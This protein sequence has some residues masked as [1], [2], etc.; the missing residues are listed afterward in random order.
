MY[1]QIPEN[2]PFRTAPGVKLQ[3]IVTLKNENS[4]YAFIVRDDDNNYVLYRKDS[5]QFYMPTHQWFPEAVAAMQL[6]PL[7]DRL[8]LDEKGNPIPPGLGELPEHWDI[9]RDTPRIFICVQY[10]ETGEEIGSRVLT[11]NQLKVKTIPGVKNAFTV[12]DSTGFP[13]IIGQRVTHD[14]VQ[15]KI[16]VG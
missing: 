6:L 16:Y 1:V 14:P 5:R 2:K 3:P 13:Q 12:V 11:G 4:D 9:S 10:K 8:P 15:N 7:P